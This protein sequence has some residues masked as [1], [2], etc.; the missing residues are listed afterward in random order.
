MVGQR[1]IAKEAGLCIA[2]VSRVLTGKADETGCV[3]PETRR[4]VR[5]AAERLGYK[6]NFA[7]RMLRLGRSDAIGLL[8]SAAS[9][10]YMELVPRL[11]HQIFLRGRVAICGFWNH[12]SDAESTIEAIAAREVDGIITCHW[13]QAIRK[14]A[15]G[16]P[17]VH[18]LSD[19]PEADCVGLGSML[20]MQ[21]RHLLDLGHRQIVFFG[22]WS[23]GGEGLL[24]LAAEQGL[25]A[26]FVKQD[27]ETWQSAS[28][29]G[30]ETAIELFCRPDAPGRPTALVCQTDESAAIAIAALVQRGFRVP[31]DISVGSAEGLTLGA[32]FF[33]SITAAGPDL[34]LLA[35]TLVETLLRRMGDSKLPPQRIMVPLS[36]FRREST[37]P[38][39]KTP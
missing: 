19:D 33:P 31:E 4:R 35:E 26:T 39:P 3:R 13:P 22:P 8:F 34:D 27:R 36:L 1:D 30:L 14:L 20:E 24:R 29:G 18:F 28:R 9:D 25:R 12:E 16:I 11:Q 15:P 38:A 6:L 32:R 21:T 7:G 23:D 17:A 2:T 10:L 5:E 37:G